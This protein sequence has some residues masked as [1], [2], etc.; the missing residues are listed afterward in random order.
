MVLRIQDDMKVEIIE[1][2]KGGKGV[3]KVINFFNQED[4]LGKGRLYGMSV[5]EP[6]HSIGYHQ[7]NGDQEA[8]YIL[9]G[10]A[11]Y[12]DNGEEHLLKPGDLAICKEGDFH[13]IESVGEDNLEYIML[14]LFT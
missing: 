7:H 5:I 14:I 12:V 8:Y 1:G 10:E 2:L 3:V 4:F 11:K 13:S 6:G 9:K